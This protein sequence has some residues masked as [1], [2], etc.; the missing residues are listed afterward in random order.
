MKQIYPR[1]QRFIAARLTPGEELGLHFTI[2]VVLML[3]AAWVFGGIAEDVVDAEEITILDQWLAQWF[4]ARAT[5]GFTQAMLL[6]THV[7]NT[8]GMLVMTAVAGIYFY[9]HRAR[10]WLLAL[11]LTVPGGML[12]NVMLKHI[13]QR[14]RPSLDNPLLTLATYSFPSGHTVAATLFY[15]FIAAYLVCRHGRW[16]TRALIVA[17]ACLMVALVGLSRMY[18]GVHYLSDVLAAIAEGCGWLAVCITGVSTL[19]RRRAARAS[20]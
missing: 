9:L 8:A 2:G 11:I 1:V 4:H 3:A 14:T 19:R 18:L 13:F 5:P 10:Y 15:G 17:A 6:L 7:H 20:A 12:L 16:K